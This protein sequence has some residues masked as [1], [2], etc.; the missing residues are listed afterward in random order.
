MG[1]STEVRSSIDTKVLMV[2]AAGTTRMPADLDCYPA[3]PDAALR[4]LLELRPDVVLIDCPEECAQALDL[5]ASLRATTSL[6][7][8]AVTGNVDVGVYALR[9][10]ADSIVPKPISTADVRLRI[11][12]LLDRRVRAGCLPGRVAA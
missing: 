9:A 10:G 5:I 4:A 12:R 1:I 2:A 7:I 8:L 6:P 11:G 3:P